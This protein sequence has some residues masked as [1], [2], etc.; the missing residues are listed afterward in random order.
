NVFNDNI[1]EILGKFQNGDLSQRL[2][3]E[4]QSPNIVK[5]KSVMNKMAQELEQNIV[6]VL[7]VIDEY[8]SYKY[9]NKVDIT[10]FENHI[11]QLA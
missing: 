11:L 2:N 5:L 3:I 4:V 9:L 10:K 7:K 8:S 1:I 6:N